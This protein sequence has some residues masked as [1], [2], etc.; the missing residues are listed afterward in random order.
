MLAFPLA[1]SVLIALAWRWLPGRTAGWIGSA[2]IGIAFLNSVAML[3][4]L[5]DRPPRSGI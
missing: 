5:Q 1:G 4:R 3:L 2:A